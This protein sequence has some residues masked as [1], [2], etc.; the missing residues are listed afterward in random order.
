MVLGWL[1]P[2]KEERI[3]LEKESKKR[4]G[5]VRSQELVS[6]SSLGIDV[7]CLL[8]QWFVNRPKLLLI[9]VCR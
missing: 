4:A 9:N 1:F 2:L 5:I 8:K 6:G 7:S 3:I